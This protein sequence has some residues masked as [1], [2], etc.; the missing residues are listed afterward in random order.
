MVTG[1]NGTEQFISTRLHYFLVAMSFLVLAFVTVVAND[2]TIFLVHLIAIVGSFL[3]LWFFIMQYSAVSKDDSNI[4]PEQKTKE[5]VDQLGYC[6]SAAFNSLIDFVNFSRQHRGTHSWFIPLIFCGFWFLAWFAGGWWLMR[7]GY[8]SMWVFAPFGFYF[9]LWGLY[10]FYLGR[11]DRKHLLFWGSGLIA[12]L[13][14][15]TTLL[16]SLFTNYW[17]WE[18]GLLGGSLFIC[19]CLTTLLRS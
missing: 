14:S 13:L 6:I 10:L 15:L 7:E 9:A 5:P 19:I 12:F 17:P 11:A 2:V 18:I 16:L 1:T 8:W 4:S 3:S